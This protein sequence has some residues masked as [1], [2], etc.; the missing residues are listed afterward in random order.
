MKLPLIRKTLGC[1]KPRQTEKLHIDFNGPVSVAPEILEAPESGNQDT[2]PMQTTTGA[3]MASPVS[4]QAGTR[5]QNVGYTRVVQDDPV[6]VTMSS[7]MALESSTGVLGP[8]KLAIEGL[9]NAVK[10]FDVCA[11]LRRGSLA[12]SFLEFKQE[13]KRI[14][15]FACIA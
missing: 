5:G 15:R 4:V 12:E 14:Q 1:L 10:A 3:T 7:F 11:A 6:P 8:L 9:K 13:P 2:S